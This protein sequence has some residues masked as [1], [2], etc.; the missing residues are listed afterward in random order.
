MKFFRQLFRRPMK[1]ALG[2]LLLALA[3]VFLCV[4]VGQFWAAAQTRRQVEQAYT[5]VAIPTNRY[6][7][8]ELMD[9]FGNVIGVTETQD[10]PFA[11]QQYLAALPERAP[12]CVKGIVQNGLVS[13]YCPSVSPIL[14]AIAEKTQIGSDIPYD[15]VILKIKLTEIGALHD[16]DAIGGGS[17]AS[18]VRFCGTV[19]ETMA[20]A[21]GYESP[22][23]RTVY[24]ELYGISKT[25]LDGLSLRIGAEYVL[26]GY[27]YTDLDYIL[28]TSL[29]DLAAR[30]TDATPEDID[31]ENEILPLTAAEQA[32]L[33][34]DSSKQYAAKYVPKQAAE[35]A[36]YL[37]QAEVEQ[38]NAC[39]CIGYAD[40]LVLKGC[41]GESTVS[42]F[43][44]GEP[45]ELAAEEY[46]KEYRLPSIAHSAQGDAWSRVREAVC[47]NSHALPFLT[48]DNAAAIGQFAADSAFV[49]EGRFILEE[50]YET[51][52]AV[53]LI[54]ESLAVANGL[55]VGD[56][57]T[58]SLYETDYNAPMQAFF[59]TTNPTASYYAGSFAQEQ[60]FT[61]VG[62]YRQTEQWSSAD[63]AFSPNTVIVPSGSVHCETQ[64]ASGGVFLTLELYNGTQK[65][66]EDRL[67]Q[68]GY[69][70][71]FTY[72][73]H[74]Y[75]E[76]LSSLNGYETVSQTVL[77]VGIVIWLAVSFLFLLLFPLQMGRDGRRMWQLGA[78][79]R[80]RFA[81]I[82]LSGATLMLC[83]AVLS[84]FASK[85]GS[86]YVFSRLRTLTESTIALSV[87]AGQLAFLCCLSLGAQLV[88]LTLAAALMVKRSARE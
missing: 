2:I 55:S 47:V 67:L 44:D 60:S 58:A 12:D 75:A 68:D 6:Q 57:I 7:R 72:Y 13:G 88:L 79:G 84:F 45:T 22:V 81:Y 77:A 76:I 29:V 30:F 23:G 56:T 20:L 73:D 32:E 33:N 27:C 1:T 80:S 41:A 36:V 53:C 52:A 24:Y 78:G 49:T 37:T 87:S 85:Q 26:F 8:Q 18:C 16:N 40:T 25:E 28:R 11:V 46:L 64:S 69:S 21:E 59:Q 61:V 83:G 66:L 39:S 4:S 43:L 10:Q 54:S 31:W 50:E 48:T 5:T 19:M 51:G 62:L 9:E 14:P 63:G 74:G 34:T 65:L 70:G 17:A 42:V 15:A 3:G 71:L 35:H 86:Q 38:I 82:F